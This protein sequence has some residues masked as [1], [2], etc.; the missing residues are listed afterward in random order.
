MLV[1]LL[2][3][4]GGLRG[5]KPSLSEFRSFPV[6]VHVP[7]G[8]VFLPRSTARKHRH[9]QLV[10]THSLA[11][12]L[13]SGFWILGEGACSSLS[14]IPVFSGLDAILAKSFPL[15]FGTGI[16]LYLLVVAAFYVLLAVQHSQEAKERK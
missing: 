8:V 12:L 1:Y 14:G 9:V 5:R 4:P 6:R 16:L 11:A 7:L 15:L 10:L 3:V 13:V 2:A